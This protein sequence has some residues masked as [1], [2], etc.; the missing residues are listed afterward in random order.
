[1]TQSF[2]LE[3]VS[4]KRP[5]NILLVFKDKGEDSGH[6]WIKYCEYSSTQRDIAMWNI[7]QTYNVGL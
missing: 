4:F 2:E 5:S 6:V 1:M 7:V 3:P